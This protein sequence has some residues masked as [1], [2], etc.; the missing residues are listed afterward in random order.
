[1]R[2]SSIM[3]KEDGELA[4]YLSKAIDEGGLEI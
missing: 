4:S 3:A 1:M 2:D